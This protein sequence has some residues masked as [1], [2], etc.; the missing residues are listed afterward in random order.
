MTKELTIQKNDI[1]IAKKADSI[2][3]SF[4]E[5]AP[6]NGFELALV[7]ADAMTQIESILTEEYV[8]KIKTLMGKRLGF[9]SDK[10]DYS[11]AVVRNVI[12]EATFAGLQVVGNQFNIIGGKMYPTKEGFGYLLSQI[13]GLYYTHNF[14]IPRKNE[15][16][17]IIVDV[18]I[19]YKY[20]GVERK[21]KITFPVKDNNGMTSDGH[22]GKAERK[23]KQWIYNDITKKQLGEGD[24]E[25]IAHEVISSGVKN[26]TISKEVIDSI[27]KTHEEAEVISEKTISDLQRRAYNHFNSAK[28]KE[29]ADKRWNLIKKQLEEK[30][31]GW[32][33]S[34]YNQKIKEF[35]NE[36]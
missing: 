3:K 35:E 13:D 23:A 22:I 26:S 27:Q 24:I 7:Q 11:I 14:S 34:I 31:E 4:N 21:Q 29:D 9:L 1:E 25:E 17:Q 8:S 2:I 20:L 5:S 6:K 12:M 18:D 16:N 10:M 19:Y 30:G 15:S 36:K 32:D 28:T 33:I